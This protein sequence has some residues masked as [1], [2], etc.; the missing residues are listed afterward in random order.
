M[1]YAMVVPGRTC[2]VSFR[3]TDG[4]LWCHVTAAQTV[5][6]A[7]REGWDFFQDP[8]A[9]PEAKPG[10]YIRDFTRWR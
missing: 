3:T 7:A 2:I 1:R 9:R 5:F 8:L 6:N 10:N 4:K